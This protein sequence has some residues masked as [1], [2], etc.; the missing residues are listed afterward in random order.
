[1]T[2]GGLKEKEFA[3]SLVYFGGN[4]VNTFQGLKSRVTT[5]I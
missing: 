2:Q 4:G 3:W 5:Y 1:M